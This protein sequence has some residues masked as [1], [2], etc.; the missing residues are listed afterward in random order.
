VDLTGL[1][2]AR[3]RVSP[4]HISLRLDLESVPVSIDTAMPCGL[5]LNELVSNSFKY[6]FPSRQQG[7]I[8]IRLHR[9]K[10][11]QILL[12]VSDNGI[13]FPR[14]GGPRHQA[15]MGLQ[16]VLTLAEHQ[17]QGQV[18]FDTHHGTNCQIYFRNDFD[19]KKSG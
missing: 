5:I 6:A 19:D 7:E 15:R 12:Q 4:E 9:T 18:R 1:L 16:S 13:G 2:M 11:G 14:E 10:T 3:Y 17:L 8:T